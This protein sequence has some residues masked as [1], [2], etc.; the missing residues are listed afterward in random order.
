LKDVALLHDSTAGD[1]EFEL[2]LLGMFTDATGEHVKKL[3]AALTAGNKK[4][5]HPRSPLA[6]AN[7]RCVGPQ[8]SFY[9]AH[10][11]KGSALQLGAC[12][13]PALCVD[14]EKMIDACSE[15]DM[16]GLSALAGK[17]YNDL[18]A[19]YNGTFFIM[20]ATEWLITLPEYIKTFNEYL[21]T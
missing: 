1:R 19:S 12:K 17:S 3:K 9:H 14:M 8:D 5:L 16:A 2:E 13:L 20:A 11:I 18:L 15:G 4:V 21:K 10:S 7:L 6:G